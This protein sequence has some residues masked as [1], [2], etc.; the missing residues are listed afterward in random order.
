MRP[1]GQEGVVVADIAALLRQAARF[2]GDALLSA[3]ETL[4]DE[5]LTTFRAAST[6]AYQHRVSSKPD[7]VWTNTDNVFHVATDSKTAAETKQLMALRLVAKEH[8]LE[9]R[10]HDDIAR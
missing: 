4:S 3:M 8:R 9:K 10:H 1:V 5:D 7:G 6:V 2:G